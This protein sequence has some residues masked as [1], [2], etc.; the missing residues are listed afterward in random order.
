MVC[1]HE[2]FGSAKVSEGKIN[3][4]PPLPSILGFYIRP[5]FHVYT[6]ILALTGL[7][8]KGNQ[9]V[10]HEK[11]TL[12]ELTGPWKCASRLFQF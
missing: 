1:K 12:D 10:F 4:F 11:M 9:Q 6:W 5:S 8:S 7:P 2:E 3:Y